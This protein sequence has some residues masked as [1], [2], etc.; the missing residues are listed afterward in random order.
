MKKAMKKILAAVS[1]AT[2]L[3]TLSLS[4]SAEKT[5]YE[6]EIKEIISSNEHST[7]IEFN[8]GTNIVITQKSN[9]TVNYVVSSTEENVSNDYLGL[10]DKYTVSGLNQTV[11]DD[12]CI[13]SVSVETEEEMEELFE[14]SAALYENGKI[15]DAY[16]SMDII[17]S[18]F[19]YVEINGEI[20]FKIQTVNLH[21]DMITYLNSTSEIVIVGDVNGDNEL[22][23][24]DC[25][26]IART[27]A[28]REIIDIALNPAADYN[29]D[30]K[31]TVSD[32]ATIARELAKK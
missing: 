26:F 6:N 28:R 12:K 27:L 23:V 2:V 25:A 1:A 22:N 19:E 20:S 17:Y 11:K 5:F 13:Y 31:V 16:T 18:P 7:Y 4:V 21:A 10:S 30:G 8:D 9:F 29:N 3:G 32:A 24:S 14:A 15:N